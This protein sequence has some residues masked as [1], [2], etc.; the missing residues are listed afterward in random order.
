MDDVV[1]PPAPEK[2]DKDAG[3]E[4]QR[5]EDAPPAVRPVQISAGGHPN[6][7]D[8]P[9]GGLFARRPL[10]AGDVGDLV[11]FAKGLGEL[12]EPAL[13]AADCLRVDAVVD[14]R[15]PHAVPARTQS[16]AMTTATP[17]KS[18]RIPRRSTPSLGLEPR[19]TRR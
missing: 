10:P 4:R 19:S 13:R 12:A 18:G 15:D 3:G 11:F 17:T 14:E 7:P 1:A 6:P 9:S 8:A 5:R 2:V 16:L